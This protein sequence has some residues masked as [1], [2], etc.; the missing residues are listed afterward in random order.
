M[1]K[2][3]EIIEVIRTNL[4]KRGSG[5]PGDPVQIITKYWSKDGELLWEFD[6]C[7]VRKQF[8]DVLPEGEKIPE[9]P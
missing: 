8:N 7:E 2:Y 1:S 4:D 5:A 9:T 3:I 6:P